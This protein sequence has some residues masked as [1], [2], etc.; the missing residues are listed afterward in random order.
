MKGLMVATVFT[1]LA[2][3]ACSDSTGLGAGQRSVS[4]SFATAQPAGAAFAATRPFFGIAGDTIVS[5]SDMIVIDRVRMVLREIEL[6]RIEDQFCEDFPGESEDNDDC[7]EFVIGPL[8]LDLP[9]HG[10][11]ETQVSVVVDTGTY[12]EIEFQI[13]DPSDDSPGDSAFRDA[14]PLFSKTSIRVEGTFNGQ[15][16]VYETD[17]DVEQEIE[18]ADPLIVTDQTATTNVTLTVDLDTWFRNLSGGLVDPQSGNKGNVNE[19]LIK[20]NIKTSFK[21]FEDEDHDGDDDDV[22][23]DGDDS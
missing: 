5:G 9:L 15:P 7:E 2:A 22:D 11:V 4:L 16:F 1:V 18:L 13:H 21:A 19:D 6:K 12:D 3:A 14:N 23:D 8:L 17:L 10:S 20:E